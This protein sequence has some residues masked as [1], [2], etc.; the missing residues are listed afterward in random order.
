[1]DDGD[2]NAKTYSVTLFNKYYNTILTFNVNTSALCDV[3][4]DTHY[5]IILAIELRGIN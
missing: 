4:T 2:I 1:M 3:T 5:S